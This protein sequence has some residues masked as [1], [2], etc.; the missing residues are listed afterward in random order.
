MAGCG[1]DVPNRD[2]ALAAATELNT[3]ASKIEMDEE[4]RCWLERRLR[5][6]SRGAA[7]R[8]IMK[9]ISGLELPQELAVANLFDIA[10]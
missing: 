10:A 3:W 6:M 2:I 9:A 1:Y 8:A 4:V 7:A 5:E